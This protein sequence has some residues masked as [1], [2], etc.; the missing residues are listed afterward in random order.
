MSVTIDEFKEHIHFEDGM[1]DSLLDLYLTNATSY[2][3][4]ATDAESSQLILLVAAM[5]YQFKV[6]EQELESALDAL[7]PFFVAEVY[8][9]EDNDEST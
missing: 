1:D 6:P 8:D 9:A 7:T 3:K 2:V 4:R 5:F